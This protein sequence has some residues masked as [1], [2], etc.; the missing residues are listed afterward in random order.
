MNAQTDVTFP[1][2]RPATDDLVI[3]AFHDF[4]ADR[5]AVQQWSDHQTLLTDFVWFGFQ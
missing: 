2:K 3:R 1:K 5:N 4:S